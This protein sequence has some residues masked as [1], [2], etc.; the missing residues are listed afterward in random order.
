MTAREF[1]EQA[2]QIE[3]RIGCMREE[4]ARLRAML[5][6]GGKA[7]RPDR[8]PSEA[9]SAVA[10]MNEAI[11]AEV[12]ALCCVKRE[13]NAAIEAVGDVRMRRL[14]ELRYRSNMHWEDVAR[15]MGYDL[16]H[17]YRIHRLALRCVDSERKNFFGA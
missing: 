1:L 8:G 7:D 17:I 13:V 16:R 4:Q 10:A 2:W 15:E 12:L 14:L 5:D 6:A 9:E 3:G 11:E